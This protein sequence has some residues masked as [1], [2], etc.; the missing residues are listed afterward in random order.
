MKIW[1]GGV[2]RACAD[3]AANMLQVLV[4]DRC[5]KLPQLLCGDF[6]SITSEALHFFKENGVVV[7]ETPDQD[8]PDIWKALKLMANTINQK[9]L[10]IEH[11]VILGGLSGRIDHTLSSFDALLRFHSICD[12]P[13][14]IID[15]INLVTLLHKGTTVIYLDNH[16]PYLTGIAG[17]MPLCQKPTTVTSVGFKWN[18]ENASL[19]YGGCISVS[20]KIEA[21][22]VCFQTNAPLIFSLELSK[23]VLA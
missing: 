21:D 12:C 22:T 13:V 8:Y 1:N 4:R 18:L 20:N 3:G 9:N 16:E 15:D 10:K 11:L 14:F 5:V 17:F 23:N 2:Y 6:D 19:E 7:K